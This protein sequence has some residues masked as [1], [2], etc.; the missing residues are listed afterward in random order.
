MNLDK[1]NKYLNNIFLIIYIVSMMIYILLFGINYESTTI[2]KKYQI[3]KENS[4]I[5]KTSFT[6]VEYNNYRFNIPDELN[7]EVD[8]S[9]IIYNKQSWITNIQ[10]L[11]YSY[12][13]LLKYS[14]S[15]KAAIEKNNFK[16]N[17]IDEVLI[18]NHN[19]LIIEIEDQ[20]NTHVLVYTKLDNYKSYAIEVVSIDSSDY[21]S[22]VKQLIKIIETS[23]KD[24]KNDINNSI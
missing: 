1:I 14:D 6:S 11:D 13:D 4:I 3:K 17:N 7:Y 16:V 21:K 19:L 15:V 9:I 8:D 2:L 20:E 22:I 23:N 24:N 5:N 18:D 10:I 12:S